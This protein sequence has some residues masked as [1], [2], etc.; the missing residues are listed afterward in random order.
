MV[1]SCCVSC[2]CVLVL[3]S[4]PSDCLADTLLTEP[5]LASTWASRVPRSWL[6]GGYQPMFADCISSFWPDQ[7][8]FTPQ[9][10]L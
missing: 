5:P 10:P 3:N 7:L 6:P 9:D 8:L 1:M 4:G 2:P